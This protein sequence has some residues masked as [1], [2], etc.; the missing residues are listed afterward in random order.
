MDFLKEVKLKNIFLGV[1]EGNINAIRLYEKHGFK[2][3]GF[4]KNFFNINGK[5]YDEILMD[6]YL[7]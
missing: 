4:H 1:R 3:V 2:K 7:E 6:L 5:Y